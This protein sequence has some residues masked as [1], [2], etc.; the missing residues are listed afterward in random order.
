MTEQ[1]FSKMK[2][3]TLRALVVALAKD[4]GVEDN[5]IE[6]PKGKTMFNN[7]AKVLTFDELFA[8]SVTRFRVV[9]EGTLRWWGAEVELSAAR[10]CA[11]QI[12][13]ATCRKGRTVDELK[14]HASV[15]VR[16][17]PGNRD[18]FFADAARPAA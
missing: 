12:T 3:G 15:R 6:L 13:F 2:K 5:G 10:S 17:M 14:L 8:Q 7:G 11:V 1:D 9:G 16:S 18:V 4:L